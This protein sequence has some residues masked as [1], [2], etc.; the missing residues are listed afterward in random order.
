MKRL[1]IS[2]FICITMAC[3]ANCG[4][5]E[6]IKKVDLNKI[7]EMKSEQEPLKIKIGLI[8]E[9]DIRK[10]AARYEPL[11]EYLSKKLNSKDWAMRQALSL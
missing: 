5:R 6:G 4:D 11:A 3:C 9:Q 2:T 8:P 7:E 10:M 1:F